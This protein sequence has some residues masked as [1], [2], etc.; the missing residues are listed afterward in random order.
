MTINA[1]SCSSAVS[2]AGLPDRQQQGVAPGEQLAGTPAGVAF[3]E[4]S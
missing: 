3:S 4:P 1:A 2:T